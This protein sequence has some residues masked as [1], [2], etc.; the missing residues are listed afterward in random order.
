M[1]TFELPANFTSTTQIN[2]TTTTQ[3]H[4][5]MPTAICNFIILI[6]LITLPFHLLMIKVLHFDLRLALARHMITFCLSISDAL[7]V[8]IIFSCATVMKIFRLTEED[9]ECNIIRKIL[10]FELAMSLVVSSLSII[11]LSVERYVACIHSFRLHEIFTSE[12]VTCAISCIWITG[13]ICGA[14]ITAFIAKTKHNLLLNTSKSFG[15]LLVVIVIP[16]SIFVTVI[17][18]R[19]LVFSRS[20][21]VRVGPTILFGSKAEMTGLRKRQIKIAFITSIV[22]IIYVVS[23]Y[24]A[25][26]L[27]FLDLIK[28]EVSSPT[29]LGTLKT[30][31]ILNNFADPYIYG[32]GMVDTRRALFKNLRK[33]KSLFTRQ[34]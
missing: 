8:L 17:Q 9:E 34:L 16:T 20:K 29:I 12:R 11:A 7:F 15:V 18:S 26:F 2:N 33:M 10:Y 1:K 3:I 31:T 21:L 6:T 14:V 22:V 19:L 13:V 27:S 24:P 5:C 23:M 30:L 4:Q 25:A 32:I 28:H